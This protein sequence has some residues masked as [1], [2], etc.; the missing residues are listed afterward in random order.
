[1]WKL[2]GLLPSP[3]WMVSGQPAWNWT[4]VEP[5]AVSTGRLGRTEQTRGFADHAIVPNHVLLYIML[6]HEEA[7]PLVVEIRREDEQG[8]HTELLQ[9]GSVPP[10]RRWMRQVYPIPT[11][12]PGRYRAIWLVASS[13]LPIAEDVF[14]IT[15]FTGWAGTRR[16][17]Q[18]VQ[19]LTDGETATVQRAD[20]SLSV[21]VV[22]QQHLDT[23][24]WDYDVDGWPTGLNALQPRQHGFVFDATDKTIEAPLRTVLGDPSRKKEDIR[25]LGS[26]D[27]P[28]LRVEGIEEP[29]IIR[30]DGKII[31]RL[32]VLCTEIK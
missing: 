26:I 13:R 28:V 27:L 11:P 5:W 4:D 23:E 14:E 18:P 7:R 30:I 20:G 17:G 16:G 19:R 8:D 21:K 9:R 32:R 15:M 6:D 25:I 12:P 1:M 22:I 2:R 31:H 29:A 3:R 10:A 24:N